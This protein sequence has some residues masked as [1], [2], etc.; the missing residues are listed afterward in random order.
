MNA[1]VYQG[2]NQ[3]DE[4]TEKFFLALPS[5]ISCKTFNRQLLAAG[6]KTHKVYQSRYSLFYMQCVIIIWH[7][8][9]SLAI[10]IGN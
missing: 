10:R 8:R 3:A 1:C 2:R 6:Y 7:L 5:T 9:A 4:D